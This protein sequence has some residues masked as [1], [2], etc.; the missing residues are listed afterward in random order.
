MNDMVPLTNFYFII[1]IALTGSGFDKL[2]TKQVVVLYLYR[3]LDPDN[4]G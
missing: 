2:G 1:P 3:Y 4:H